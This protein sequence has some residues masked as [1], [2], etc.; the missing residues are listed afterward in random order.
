MILHHEAEAPQL[1]LTRDS[2]SVTA[3]ITDALRGG[4]IGR[5]ATILFGQ[6]MESQYQQTIQLMLAVVDWRELYLNEEE[7]GTDKVEKLET[8]IKIQARDHEHKAKSQ[9]KE[10]EERL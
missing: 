5:A 10:Y 6:D 4:E 9:K 8:D 7:E 2:G 1:Q 3:A